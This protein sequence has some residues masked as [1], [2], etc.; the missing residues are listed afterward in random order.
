MKLTRVDQ[1]RAVVQC[2][3]VRSRE[4]Q[5]GV[6]SAQVTFKPRPSQHRAN[7]EVP[8]GMTYK[9]ANKEEHKDVK[10]VHT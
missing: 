1:S 2:A 7:Y 10:Y 8:Q 5:E 9:A 4:G 3:Q 6:Q